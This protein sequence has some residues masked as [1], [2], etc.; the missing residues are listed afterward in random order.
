M[1]ILDSQGEIVPIDPPN[2]EKSQI[3]EGTNESVRSR[4]HLIL[5]L[6][7]VIAALIWQA[8]I[9]CHGNGLIDVEENR[10]SWHVFDNAGCVLCETGA[11]NLQLS[12]FGISV[13]RK[14][15]FAFSILAR[16]KK[17]D[18]QKLPRNETQTKN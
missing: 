4:Q 9:G 8:R 12:F 17:F 16:A 7:L 10:K 3:L 14:L 6:L 2:P 5:H 1:A 11:V 13:E 15:S 18:E